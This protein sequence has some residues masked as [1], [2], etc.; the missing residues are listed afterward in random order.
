MEENNMPNK[1]TKKLWVADMLDDTK[2][3]KIVVSSR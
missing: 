1:I 2:I 3:E